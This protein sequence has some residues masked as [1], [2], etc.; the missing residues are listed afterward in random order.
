MPL[1][2]KAPEPKKVPTGSNL[3]MWKCPKNYHVLWKDIYT[4]RDTGVI[5]EPKP[6]CEYDGSDERGRMTP[7]SAEPPD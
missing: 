7:A 6:A 3:N 4:G 2:T 5:F 1:D